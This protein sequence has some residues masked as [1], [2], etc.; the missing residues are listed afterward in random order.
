MNVLIIGSGGR[1]HAFAWKINQSKK[2]SNLY[3]APG[4][5]GT[6]VIATNVAVHPTDFDAIK[7]LVLEKNIELVVVGP[8]DPLVEGI[9]DF[10][11]ADEQL[12]SIGIIGPKKDGAQLEGSKEFSKS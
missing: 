12:K 10:F 6:S 11:L 4:N 7:K 1:E 3:V 9:H 8:E 2:L 5:A